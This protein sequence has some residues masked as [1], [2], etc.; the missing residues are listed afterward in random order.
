M[1]KQ[2]EWMF[3]KGKTISFPIPEGAITPIYVIGDSHVRVLPQACPNIF[4]GSGA[5]IADVF[6]SKSAYAVGTVN[7]DT[8][9]KECLRLIPDGS[10]ALLSFGEIDC[11]HYSPKKAIENNTSIEH[12]VDEVINRYTSNCVRLLKE[13][14]RVMILGPYICPE[15]HTHANKFKDIVRAKTYFNSRIAEYCD[16]NGILYIPIFHKSLWE[17][18]DE[19]RISTYFNDSSHLGPCMVPI[20]LEAMKGFQWKGFDI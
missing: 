8:Y 12:E 3:F 10:N 11:R 17:K 15:D 2:D 16:E 1:S 6:E 19:Q 14:F 13:K 9:L 18:W 5:D 7:H 4:K 20:I